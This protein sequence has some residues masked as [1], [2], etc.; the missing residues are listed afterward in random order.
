MSTTDEQTGGL[1]YRDAGVD[2]DKASA[3]LAAIGRM[4]RS[5][6]GAGATDG[7]FGHFGG[8]FALPSGPDRLL[9]A[10]ADGI[11]TKIKLAFATGG[12]AHARVGGDLVRHCVNDILACGASPLFFLDYIAMGSLDTEALEGLVEGMA[13]ACRE[14]GLALIGGETAE[15]P[16]LYAEGEY[17]AAGF[18]VGEV[19]PDCYIDGSAVRDGDLLIGFPSTGLHTN[20]YSLARKIVGLTGDRDAD[21]VLLAD[22][23]ATGSNLSIGDALLEPHRS[24]VPEVCTLVEHRL[25]RG[26]AHITGGGLLENVPRMIPDGLTAEIDPS[27]WEVPSIFTALVERGGV[28]PV[29]RYRAFNMGIGFVI[30]V[31]PSDADVVVQANSESRVIGRIVPDRA[32]SKVRLIGVTD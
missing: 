16:G 11:G 18:I 15:M 13:D 25:V 14:N 26:M 29:D 22:P 9:V 4:A 24:Y 28:D 19:A 17:D 31:A 2:I 32:E 12:W 6:M 5:T 20:G 10:S 23:L 1:T 3:S 27:T 30:A 21:R 8:V 7:D